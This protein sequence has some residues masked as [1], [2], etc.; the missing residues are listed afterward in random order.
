M[1]NDKQETIPM[2]KTVMV[3][4]IPEPKVRKATAK[5]VRKHKDKNSLQPQGEA[6]DPRMGVLL[7]LGS[8]D[9]LCAS[10]VSLV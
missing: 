1:S 9:G 2:G 6:Q 7:C 5:P 4:V 8:C 10:G 3:L